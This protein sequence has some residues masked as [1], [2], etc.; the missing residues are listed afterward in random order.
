MGECPGVQF[1]VTVSLRLSRSRGDLRPRGVLGGGQASD[2]AA[3]RPRRGRPRAAASSERV[4]LAV[5]ARG[6]RSSM[7]TPCPRA[8]G[9]GLQEGPAQPR[10][11]PAVVGE[12]PLGEGPRGLDELRVVEQSRAPAAA[13]SCSRRDTAQTS[14]FGASKAAMF[15][16]GT[17]RFQ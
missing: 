7:P 1:R 2:R 11:V 5:R 10:G 12:D 3:T 13:W 17:V 16:G 6:A 14:R 15:G 9:T 4:A 8:G